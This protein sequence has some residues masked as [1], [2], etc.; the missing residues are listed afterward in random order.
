MR[1]GLRSSYLLCHLHVS[2][3]FSCSVLVAQT[4]MCEG[5][6]RR[7][8][9]ASAGGLTKFPALR[10]ATARSGNTPSER[11]TRHQRILGLLAMGLGKP[12]PAEVGKEGVC[13]NSGVVG[14]QEAGRGGRWR[15]AGREVNVVKIPVCL[16]SLI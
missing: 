11:N 6:L 10:W 9:W 15:G 4:I 7:D 13:L 1:A 16:P 12:C 3:L 8:R 5:N 2:S 14:A